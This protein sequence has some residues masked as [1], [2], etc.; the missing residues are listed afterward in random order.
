MKTL[1]RISA[2]AVVALGLSGAH[3]GAGEPLEIGAV[4]PLSGKLS[5]YGEGFQKAMLVAVNKINAAGG[6]AGKKIRILFEDNQSTS[7]GSV[8]A[9]QKLI[10]VSKVPVIFGPAA[11]TN[12][13]AVCPIAQT[14]GVVLVAAES[15]AAK[16]SDCGSYVYR[17]FPSDALQG[18][19]VSKLVNDLGVRKVA[20]TYVNNDWGVGLADTFKRE[21]IAAGGEIAGEFAHDEGKADYR[22]EVLRLKN[23][24]TTHVVNLTYVKEGATMLKQAKQAGFAPKWVMGSATRSP[25]FVELAGGAAEGVVGTFPKVAKDAAAFKAYAKAWAQ[26]HGDAKLPIFGGYNYDMVMVV[27]K[28][29]GNAS[30]YTADAVRAALADAGKAYDGATGNKAFD[31]NGDIVNATYGAWIVKDGKI[32]DFKP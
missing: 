31:A 9:I 16:I 32:A 18:K 26:A 12:F 28:A 4:T 17:V 7:Q 14:A 1:V 27:A 29:I 11:S 3:A 22:A 24:A 25:K 10:N 15:A 2:A 19:G 21:F 8:S 6:V 23:Y 13:L 5:I 30:A 20:L